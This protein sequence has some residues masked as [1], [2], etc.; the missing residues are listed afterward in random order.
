MRSEEQHVAQALL[1]KPQLLLAVTVGSTLGSDTPVFSGVA[2]RTK[3][4]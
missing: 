2:A 1:H 3:C 4:V